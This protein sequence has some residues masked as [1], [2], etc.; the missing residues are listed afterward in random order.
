MAAHGS[1]SHH[2]TKPGLK[3]HNVDEQKL[4]GVFPYC[5]VY[6]TCTSLYCIHLVFYLFHCCGVVVFVNV[7]TRQ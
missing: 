1:Q 7:L 2:L 5:K 3:Y 6:H 4:I